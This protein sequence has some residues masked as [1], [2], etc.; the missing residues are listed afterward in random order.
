MED[1]VP[2]TEEDLALLYPNPQL[3]AQPLFVDNFIK[4]CVCVCVCVHACMDMHTCSF[5]VLFNSIYIHDLSFVS[6]N[7]SIATRKDMSSMSY[8]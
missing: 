7:C 2:F 5:R 8:S 4:V 3:D 1:L 6:C